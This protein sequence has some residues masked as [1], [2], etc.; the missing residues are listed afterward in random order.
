VASPALKSNAIGLA[1]GRTLRSHFDGFDF[2]VGFSVG[3]SLQL[4]FGRE[5]AAAA[6][7]DA[8]A[9]SVR[10]ALRPR[11]AAGYESER[12]RGGENGR[13]RRRSDP[14][15]RS[16]TRLSSAGRGPLATQCMRFD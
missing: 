6:E 1:F 10:R 9:R 4:D 16:Q 14:F 13:A 5:P 11:A 15:T 3:L 2:A 12:K 8:V 7:I